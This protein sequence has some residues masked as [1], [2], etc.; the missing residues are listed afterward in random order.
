MGKLKKNGKENIVF[1]G[2]IHEV[3]HLPMKIGDKKKMFEVV[4]RSPG[5]RLIIVQKGKMLVTKEYRHELDGYD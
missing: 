4:R 3:V 1:K 2:K 5:V